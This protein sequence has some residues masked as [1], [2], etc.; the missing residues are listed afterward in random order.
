M[1]AISRNGRQRRCHTGAV[2]VSCNPAVK[3]E[4]NFSWT[5]TDEVPL[6]QVRR[7]YWQGICFHWRQAPL[8]YLVL[9]VVEETTWSVNAF[10]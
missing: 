1:E 5:T 9:A 10:V 3:P 7:L 8:E 2:L 6:V 4:E